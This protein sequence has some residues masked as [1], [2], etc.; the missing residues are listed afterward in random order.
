MRCSSCGFDN[1]GGGKFC[2][3]CGTPLPR[4]CPRCGAANA[5]G[6]KFCAECGASTSAPLVARVSDTQPA[7]VPGERRH[8]T[9]LFCDLVGSTTIS[10]RLDPEEWR[11]IEAEYLAAVTEAIKRFE[12]YVAK[13][14]GDGVMAYFGWPA[15][16]DNDA[17][18]AARAGLAIVDAVG[19]LNRRD[20]SGR[21]SVR[22][23]IDTGNVV[24]GKGGGSDSEVFG[25]TANVASRVQ[26]AADPNTVIFTPAVHRLISG[27]FVVVELGAHELKGIA[28]PIELFRVVRP[29]G[30][31]SRLAASVARGL[32]PF[33]GREDEVRLQW[34][35]W[36]RARGGE[37]QVIFIIGEAGM[38]KSRLVRQ[39]R[40]RL[41]GTPHTWNEC[42]GASYFQNT[43]FYPI[44][45]M[46]QQGFAERGAVTDE[47]KVAELERVLDLAGLK[48]AEAVPLLAPMLGL[49]I[50]E[51]YEPLTI[52][53]QQKRKRL[54][55]SLAGWLFGVARIQPSVM[56][57]EDLH[58]FDA[59]TLELMQLL[60]EQGA[61]SP[62]LILC[63]ARPEFPPPWASR[64]H[65]TQLTL[66]RLAA[67]EV[68][69][70]V[71]RVVAENALSQDTVE[72][73]IERT[74]GIPLFVEELTRAVLEKG[75]AKPAAREIPHTLRDSLMARL[76]RL[77]SA[78]EVA[79]I[80]A[81]VGRKF[82]YDLLRA[83][84]MMPEAE[85]Q[86]ALAK[87]ADAE[88][89]YVK[90]IAPEATYSFKHALV[91][92]AAYEALL[93]SRRRELHRTVAHVLTEQFPATA[94]AEPEVLARHWTEAGEL[95]PAMAGWRKA[96]DTAVERY[97]FKE[98]EQA[99][100]HALEILKALPESAERDARELELTGPFV[101]VLQ[102]TRGYGAPEAAQ[103][104]ARTQALAEKTNNL[105]EVIHHLFDAWA[106]VVT[107]GDLLAAGAIA[108]QLLD[109]AQSEGS[110]PSIGVAHIAQVLVR[111]WRG[112]LEGAE[113]H[114]LRRAPFFEF[115]WSEVPGLAAVLLGNAAL[116]AWQLG[117]SDVA[118]KRSSDALAAAHQMNSPFERATAH[119]IAAWLQIYLRDPDQAETF[120]SQALGLAEQYGF[121]QIAAFARITL[122]RARASLGHA[123]ES[124]AQIGR[125]LSELAKT[126]NR[127]TM[128]QLLNW[129]AEAQALADATAEA[130]ATIEEALIANP[131]ELTWRA[132][133][134]RVRGGLRLALGHHEAAEADL[135]EAI[136][137]AR[138]T[139]AKAWELRAVLDLAKIFKR[140]GDVTA[141]RGLLVPLCATLTEGHDTADLK[142]AKVLL[143]ELNG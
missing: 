116:V 55:T 129:L 47:E 32:T 6:A 64:T 114:L 75:D 11:E 22:V 124:V 127:N 117:R 59:S 113:E 109:L 91:Q 49:P 43:P 5:S 96:A 86:Q 89:I 98:A 45:D 41:A 121:P 103:A 63:T 132:D 61:T 71:A 25:D 16:H 119:Y 27:L 142:D 94:D 77:G 62:L 79:Q 44:T 136:E 100:R 102:V 84:S 56:A 1:S 97:A 9:V 65:H 50:G 7:E 48:P 95:E 2:T 36:E 39:F 18:R 138:K 4:S 70:L 57:V 31:R 46:L 37:G 135:H 87:L 133:A 105:P 137:L 15:A 112:D 68:R 60:V 140:R 19:A 82:S 21:L 69:D 23:G 111:A 76:D 8:L 108:D 120:A 33:V 85:L 139:N 12:G 26:S 58:W 29:S 3:E 10:A 66:N 104:A 14:L 40:E 38:G 126:G 106:A 13:Y 81:V 143:K 122:G 24:I 125:G 134:L 130:L 123:S 20:G 92:D 83:V 115:A 90:G 30:A 72:Q 52:T 88:L 99:Y 141:A 101:R 74:S 93:K 110:S 73:V 80:A 78:K 107:A 35:R 42:S 54:L 67:R 131:E 128:T 53:P 118:R 34:N 51:K 17:E 28:E